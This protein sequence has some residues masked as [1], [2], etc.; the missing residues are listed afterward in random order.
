MP[1]SDAIPPN[2]AALGYRTEAETCGRCSYM[3]GDMCSH[4]M[5]GQQVAAGDSCAAFEPK[6]GGEMGG[7]PEMETESEYA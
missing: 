5:I 1:D 3:E 4:P 2:P 6:A 7:T